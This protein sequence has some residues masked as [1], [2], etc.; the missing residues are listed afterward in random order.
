MT[1]HL[2]AVDVLLAVTAAGA[3]P[4]RST[5]GTTTPTA[6]AAASEALRRKLRRIGFRSFL[7]LSAAKVTVGAENVSGI[8]TGRI[9]F[10]KR[11]IPIPHRPM[12]EL[13]FGT[14]RNMLQ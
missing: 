8:V 5:V 9:E 7:A 12:G 2:C 1:R 4:I 10:V 11:H 13:A 14:F 3:D 6:T